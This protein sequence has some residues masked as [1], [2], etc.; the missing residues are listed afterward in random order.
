MTR[1]VSTNNAEHYCWGA[2]AAGWHLLN[3]DTLSVIQE[4]MPPGTFEQMHYHERAQQLFYVLSGT[5]TFKVADEVYVV[6][7]N[8]SIHIPKGVRHCIYNNGQEDLSFLV[9]SEPR[10]HGDRK[11][12]GTG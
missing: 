4:R 2:D 3:S 9:I 8:E 6:H 1:V 12:V 11:E 7:A 5:A 10:S